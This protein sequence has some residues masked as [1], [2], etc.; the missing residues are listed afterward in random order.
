MFAISGKKLEL[1]SCCW[2]LRRWG[3]RSQMQ[4]RFADADE[5]TRESW[6]NRIGRTVWVGLFY[7]SSSFVGLG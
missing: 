2:L 7:Y 5:V 6:R 4:T 3:K 1:D